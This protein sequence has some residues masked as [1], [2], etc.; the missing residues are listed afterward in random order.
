MKT[1]TITQTGILVK[2]QAFLN[3]WG[4]GQASIEMSPVFIPNKN[5]SGNN[6]LRAVNDAGFGCE[7]IYD[8]E[9]DIYIKFDN[10][11][12]EYDRTILNN[13][14]YSNLFLGWKKL[15]EQGINYS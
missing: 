2:G 6:I 15:Q 5:I 11:S 10:G 4:G 7:N 9:I 3:L 12:V 8:A 1:K 13:S 14:R